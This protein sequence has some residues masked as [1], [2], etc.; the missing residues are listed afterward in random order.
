MVR[1]DGKE[2]AISNP[3]KL[4]FPDD[5][6]TKGD[7]VDYYHR[8]A[9]HMIPLV[10]DRPLHMNRY[11]DGIGGILIQQKR[12]PD[13]FP[14]WIERV[15][16]DLHKGGTITHAVIN[17]AATLVYLANYNMITAHVWLSRIQAPEQPD[18]LIFD[19]DPSGDD[20][21]L[22]RRTAL[23][24]KSMLEDLK[25]VPFVKTTG[26]RGL[27][28]VVPIVVGP[29]FEEVHI[30]A[31]YV[32]QRLA[33]GDPDHLTTEFI[34]QKRE[35]RLF[36]DVNRNAYA[37][38]VVAPYGVRAR[39]RAPVAVPI[40]WPDVEND[41]LRPDGITI[42]TI[43]DWL[44]DHGD[45]WKPMERS[46]RPIPELDKSDLPDRSGRRRGVSRKERAQSS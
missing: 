3:T 31:D 34:K 30:F 32:G 1:V 20:F 2:I 15:T 17:N 44:R 28:V 19:L 11:P 13:S 29:S 39:R 22:V 7:L 26:S 43:W 5:G 45:S 14:P 24:L 27:H 36:I 18:L 38:T 42:A 41:A 16:V 33:A 8:I 21:G 9:G 6:I 35:G 46:R 23:S 12:V 37:Q 10:R 25:L 40:G 4:L